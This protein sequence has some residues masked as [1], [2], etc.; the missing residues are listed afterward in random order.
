[1]P[2]EQRQGRI[3][4][5]ERDR[6]AYLDDVE[7][8][9]SG[10][11]NGLVGP[12]GWLTVILLDWLRPGRNPIG[13]D[14]SNRILLS[15]KAPPHVGSIDLEAGRV[16]GRFLPEAGVTAGGTP[17]T[18]IEL[19]DDTEG[20]PTV[21]ELG[22]LSFSVI[23][24]LDEWAVRVRDRDHPAR[25]SFPG[26]EHWPVDPRWRIEARF[27]PNDPV[28]TVVVPTL[29]STG[30]RY[31]LP[32]TLRFPID[33]QSCSL[34]AL[35]ESGYR[36]YLVVFADETTGRETYGGGR[37]VYVLPPDERGRTV[38]DFNRAYN[39]PCV[40]TPYATCPVPPPENRLPVRVEAGE[41]RYTGLE[42]G[43]QGR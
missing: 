43:E 31:E 32:G 16:V 8:W 4:R 3:A 36:D 33:R 15:G 5:V 34:I 29:L 9:R 30:D 39:P 28:P 40:F 25:R 21:L 7:R 42:S 13:S 22:P 26:I 37:F 14:P 38:I 17:V 19:R 41:K 6:Q 18:T 23:R 1:M 20:S 2:G 27:D 24:R 11:L 10:R 35:H 12:R